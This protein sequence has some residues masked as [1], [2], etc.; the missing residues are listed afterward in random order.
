[1]CS[2]GGGAVGSELVGLEI[3]SAETTFAWDTSVRVRAIGTYANGTAQ[4]LT[5]SVDW[6]TGDPT[7]AVISGDG[8]DSRIVDGI[9]SGTTLVFARSGEVEGLALVS[10]TAAELEALE[11]TAAGQAAV[12][13]S[14]SYFATGVFSDGS[15]QDMTDGAVW[16]SSD[17]SVL[18]FAS[19]V[20]DPGRASA[21]SAGSATVSAAVDGVAVEVEAAVLALAVT[22]VEVA[23]QSPQIAA[24]STVQLTATA[25]F[26]DDSTQD[27]T[28]DADWGSDDASVVTVSNQ[29]GER[30]L[31]TSV[32]SG[33]TV[34]RATLGSAEGTA[35]F[36]VTEAVLTSVA[37]TPTHPSI[38]AGT[39]AELTATGGYSDGST[40]DLTHL[41]TWSSADTEVVTVSNADGGRGIATGVASGTTE[42][43]ATLEG[44]TGSTD[45]DVTAAVLASLE[46]TPASPAIASGTSISLTATGTYSDGSNQD[47]TDLVT[48]TTSDASVVTV[49]NAS[50]SEGRA[51]AIDSGSAEVSAV[52][53]GVTGTTDVE[54]TDATLT[55]VEVSPA[56][57]AMAA[58]TSLPLSATGIYSDATTQELTDVVTWATSDGGVVTV[59]N[60]GGSEG[61]ATAVAL[62][63]AEVSATLGGLTGTADVEVTD[64]ELTAIDVTPA[65]PVLAAGTSLALTAIGTYSD[66]TTQELTDVV[67]WATSDGGVVT[68]SNAGG[69]EG[70][71]TAV[72]LGTAEVSA[73]LGGLS[74]TTD[75]EVT[76]AELT[77]LD[78]TPALPLLA[79]GTS[80]VLT[81]TGTYSDATTQEL[82]DV[83]T[84]ATSDGGVVTVSN[85]GGSEGL[86]TAVALGTAEVSA[87]L[88]GLSG[89]TDVE[90]TDAE[91]TA[92]DVTPAL[93]SLAA[94][95][96]LQLTATGTYSDAST[97][98][99][100]AAV[101]WTSADA[102]VATVSNAGGSE[103]LVTAVAFGAA[104]VSAMLDGVTGTTD[105]DVTS[106]VLTSIDVTPALPSLAAGTSL[107]L[108]ATGTYSDASTQDLTALVT[109]SSDDTGVVTVSNAGG[110]EG[111][112]TA[113]APGT[114]DITAT[115]GGVVGITDFDVTAAVLTSIAVSPPSPATAVGL[116]VALTAT[117]TYS[118]A[119]TQDLTGLVTWSSADTGV[120]T[121]SNA[122]GS[123]GLATGI[124][125]GAAEISATLGVVVGTADLDVTAAVL[126]SLAITPSVPSVL[127]GLTLQLTATGTYSDG[128]MVDLTSAVTWSSDDLAIVVVSNLPGT[129][130]VVLGV[131][132]GGADLTATYA[133]LDASVALTVSP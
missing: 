96:S 47:L 23:P 69:S 95:T 12:G 35:L 57:P 76:D 60:A 16:S 121:V 85:A 33:S 75:V 54:V 20:C 55:A 51:T 56:S 110:S 84:W 109:W 34:V 15:T 40:Q 36:E 67:T 112:A 14:I 27:V 130:G 93:P 97:Q 6:S 52:L 19:G 102:A 92:L 86:A 99:L 72:A 63:T 53:G 122:G 38:A 82:T 126:T 73:T 45:F 88:G 64:A 31:A 80:L 79:A 116:A 78:V 48:W 1:M 26:S 87:T 107:A 125:I 9:D 50:G 49:S 37:V 120:V 115:L 44:V 71:A 123:E 43:S 3:A 46:V 2:C 4:D 5:S 127:L 18:V 113:V 77:A 111:L 10:V 101:T 90:V 106:A 61:L 21:L 133:S 81:A 100:S 11:I 129:E 62:G 22:A 70:L 65:L 131:A 58:G 42:V 13:T 132:L 83:V 91:L 114:A 17:E 41:V 117:G 74:G 30:G 24:G 118:D 8:C 124:A 89:T 68:V 39:S 128:S 7:V 59:S 98:D 25:T 104:E 66:A 32:D 119:S 103:G 108:T 29:A 94:G 28:E 105:V